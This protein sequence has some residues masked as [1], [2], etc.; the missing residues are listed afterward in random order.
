MASPTRR[1][2][3]EVLSLIALT[4]LVFPRE[5]AT[6]EPPH[7]PIAVHFHLDR[8]GFVTLVVEDEHGM[9]VRNLVSETYF[10][11]GDQVAW[12]DGLDDLERDTNAAEHAVYD[13]PGRTVEPGTYTVRGLYREQIDLK[14][15][16]AIYNPGQPPWMT[17]DTSSEWLTT[18]TP[19]GTVCFIPAGMVPVHGKRDIGSPSQV[20]IG[21]AVAE[22]GSGLAW[23][24]LDGN[25]LHGQTWVGG[26]WTGAQQIARDLGPHSVPGVYAYVA[27]SWNGELRLQ[28][29]VNHK[30]PELKVPSDTRFGSGEDQ[31]I[32][33]S[34]WKYPKPDLE[35]L[36][37]IAVYD[38]LL[39]VSLAKMDELLLVDAALPRVI[40]MFP[41]PKP[42]GLFADEKGSLFVISQKKVLKIAIPD[43]ARTGEVLG[44]P[45]VIVGEGLEDPQ[46]VTMDNKRN[47]YISDWGTSN[48]VKIFSPQGKFLGS[49]GAAGVPVSGP[50]NPKLMH[51]P[52]GITIDSRDQLWVA[53]ED[54][55]PKR[56]SL[57]SLDGRLLRAFYGPV[58]YGGGGNLDPRDKTLFYLD[59][60]TFRL[61][62]AT[63]ESSLIEIYH[64]PRDGERELVPTTIGKTR[65]PPFQESSSHTQFASGEN[66]DLPL[67]VAG[68]RYFTNAYNSSNTMGTPVVGIWMSK[69][70]V[71]VPVAAFGRADSRQLFVTAAFRSHIPMSAGKP[72]NLSGYTFVWSDLNDNGVAEPEEITMVPGTVDAVTVSTNLELTTSTA[73]SYKPVSFTTGGAPVYDLSK[74]Q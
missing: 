54:F 25:K 72:P 42:G 16:F 10:P 7:P 47:L 22:G 73:M 43:R 39:I 1:I 11:A 67:Y 5:K 8:P 37:G 56:V 28:K 6:K 46:Q 31:A 48:Q 66:P 9:R 62:W 53:E 40:G 38:G 51:H 70:G 4:G 23:V 57:W 34:N 49:V 59:G 63:G 29:L 52:K 2:F 61:N 36:G 35:G 15:E 21:S 65:N 24:D 26:I 14:Y 69:G 68:R 64:R 17:S 33:S 60:M 30:E 44:M 55:Q 20:L 32:L 50:Y 41:I 13:V 19:A 45:E 12:W 71:A 74:G 18:H 27:S 3:L 58:T